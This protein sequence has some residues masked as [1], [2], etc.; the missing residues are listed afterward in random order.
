MNTAATVL[1]DFIDYTDLGG[2][3]NKRWN[4]FI[5]FTDFIDLGGV[6]NEMRAV[7]IDYTDCTDWV[8]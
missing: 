8:V 5:D 2:V 4:D 1:I 7:F 3:G 6:G